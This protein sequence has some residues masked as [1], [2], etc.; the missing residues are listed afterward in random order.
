MA[1]GTVHAGR[2]G[3]PGRSITS[4]GVNG[5]GHLIIT[6]SDG[7]TQDAGAL[8][9]GVDPGT[10]TASD[11]TDSTALGRQI[12]TLATGTATTGQI[13][14]FNGTNW[15]PVAETGGVGVTDGDKGDITVSGTGATWTIDADAVT[16]SKLDNMPPNTIKINNT[17]GTTSPIDGTVAQLMA[18][19]SRASTTVAGIAELSTSAEAIAG[20][21]PATVITPATLA[22]V[23]AAWT[24]SNVK[25]MPVW[26]GTG[27][28]PLRPTL[29]AGYFV[30]WRQA[31]APLTTAGYALDGDE[32]EA[33]G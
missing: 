33:T 16:N 30:I 15:T 25:M 26:D 14:K 32:W 18:M 28:H 8:P 29:P 10:V 9:S 7:T 5:S 24:S 1:I 4:T 13:L 23:L 3:V 20:T 6:Y 22:A 31:T 2:S 17:A 21:D 11:I 27:S 19:L 12:L